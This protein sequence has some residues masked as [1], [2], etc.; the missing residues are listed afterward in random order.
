MKN[1]QGS[2]EVSCC[3]KPNTRSCIEQ[4]VLHPLTLLTG[5]PGVRIGVP[6]H[7]IGAEDTLCHDASMQLH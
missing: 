1:S 4:Q 2:K 3:I 6:Q 7:E 5:P